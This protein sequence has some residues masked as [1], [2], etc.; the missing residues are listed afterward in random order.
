MSS[1]KKLD[2][3]KWLYSIK[4]WPGWKKYSKWEW[5]AIVI[6]ILTIFY[7]VINMFTSLG[8]GTPPPRSDSKVS[9]N[10]MS[11]F[12]ETLA[13]SVHST[14]Y[15]E[16]GSSTPT[17]LTNGAE[18][19]PDLLREIQN[20]KES[21]SITDYI[22]D[23]GDFGNTIFKA[24]IVK[25]Q[26]GVKVKVLLDGTAGRKANKDLIKQLTANG[27]EVAYFRPVK[28]W[29][30]NRIDRRTHVRDFVIDG[31]TAYLGGIAISDPWLG[32]A[33]SSTS[34]HDFMFKVSGDM[35]DESSRVFENMWSQTTGE[36]V[37]STGTSSTAS[38]TN[39]N[40]FVPLFSTPSAD[41]SSNMEHF[42]W[43]SINAA[44][45][46]IHIEN[47][48]LLPSKSILEAL[49]NKARKGIDVTLIVPGKNTDTK[50]TRW[51]SQS[52]Y[53]ELLKAG[54]KVYEYQPSRIHAKIMIVDNKWSV[55]G[56]A[57]LDNRSSQINLEYI[58]GLDNANF[59]KNLESKFQT[60]I[61]KSKEI[62]RDQWDGTSIYFRPIE[63]LSKLFIKQY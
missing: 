39:S 47:P 8:D 4:K 35:A 10:N 52:Y 2:T 9:L 46:S 5:A 32:D 48:Y 31:K 59:A 14:V 29:N 38:I 43:L 55:I 20:A 62:N 37:V 13:H 45:Q 49:E 53:T 7:V 21:I 60:D 44:E 3:K 63:L 36:I 56:S 54:V 34:W 11:Q 33:T 26:E 15:P 42:V 50:Y 17:I 27:G 23:G 57:N 12:E 1:I 41:M 18:F 61:Q 24:L 40:H 58:Q 25:A 22:W 19:L 16:S 28:W 51:A 30:I 6:G